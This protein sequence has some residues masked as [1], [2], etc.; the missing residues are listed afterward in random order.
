MS[1][2]SIIVAATD[3][4]VIGRNNAMPWHLKRDLMRFKELTTGSAFSTTVERIKAVPV[5][6]K[7][8]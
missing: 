7:L 2:Y 8:T 3:N 6:M 4:N 1:K 5:K